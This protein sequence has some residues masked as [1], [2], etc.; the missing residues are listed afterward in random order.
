MAGSYSLSQ[1]KHAN[2]EC[3]W[4]VSGD[5]GKIFDMKEYGLYESASV[6]IQTLKTDIEASRM[7]LRVDDV[8]AVKKDR[9]G[10]QAPNP[11]DMQPE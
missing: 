3:S 5:T 7:I 9:E 1:A 6:K 10:E 4:G 8:Q 11:E 2:G